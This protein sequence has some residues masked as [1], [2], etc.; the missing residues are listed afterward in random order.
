MKIAFFTDTFCPTVNGIVTSI[1]YYANGLVA[2]GHDV[3]I[4][5]PKNRESRNKTWALDKRVKVMLVP[6]L[7]GKLYPDIRI[8]LPTIRGWRRIQNYDPDIIHTFTPLVIG[9]QGMLVAK[10]LKKSLV[11]SHLTNYTD[12]ETL[13]AVR[14]FPT[15]LMKQTQRGAGT[16][17]RFFLN[18]HTQVL[19]PTQ[20]TAD[21]VRAMGVTVP[22]GKVLLPVDIEALQKE[23][24]AG[25]KYRQLLGIEESIL[26]A[27]RLSGEKNIDKVLEVFS[28]VLARRPKCKLVLIG[29]GA[30]SEFLFNHATQLRVNSSII[31]FGKLPHSEI[32]NRGLYALGDIFITLS[33][34]E[35]QGL[36][37]VE[38]MACGLPV[39]G[40]RARATQEVI[41]ECGILVS[42]QKRQEIA[43]HIVTLLRNK[44]LY[45]KHKEL[46]LEIAK[47]YSV[48]RCMDQLIEVYAGLGTGI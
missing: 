29:D 5:A 27:G 19:V 9:I 45:S 40:A 44:K 14:H 16:L 10:Q 2:E 32:V 39:I 36:S 1:V 6:S 15:L 35:T 38:A 41:E 18:S 33:E 24:S 28:L 23:L 37:T 26:Y 30:D 8:G 31:W 43:D 22:I 25:K 4:I 47:R 48:R 13:K 3:F 20:D 21:D 17:I 42:P 46:S 34:F 11:T 7:D 12:E